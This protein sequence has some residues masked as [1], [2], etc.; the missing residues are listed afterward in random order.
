MA[1]RS[2]KASHDRDDIESDEKHRRA[3]RTVSMLIDLDLARGSLDGDRLVAL[4]LGQYEAT[5]M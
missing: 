3:L 5:F 2:P 4:V 1:A